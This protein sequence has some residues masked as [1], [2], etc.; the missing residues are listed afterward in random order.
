MID[1]DQLL[2]TTQNPYFTNT[3]SFVQ[4]LREF[5]EEEETKEVIEGT[6]LGTCIP[7]MVRSILHSQPFRT[8]LMRTLLILS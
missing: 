8:Y 4:D 3:G 2:E 7:G 1:S 5:N 6:S